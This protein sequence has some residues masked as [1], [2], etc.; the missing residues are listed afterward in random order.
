MGEL[1][2]A[3]PILHRIAVCVCARA[4]IEI[5]LMMII[6]MSINNRYCF[7]TKEFPKQLT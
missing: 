7:S 4:S 3:P 5:D 1:G 6:T 2:P